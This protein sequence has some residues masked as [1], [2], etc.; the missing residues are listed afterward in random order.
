MIWELRYFFRKTGRMSNILREK[1]SYSQRSLSTESIVSTDKS[2]IILGIESSCDDSGCG[3]VDINKN[4]L[5]EGLHSQQIMHL[6]MGGIIPPIAGNIHRQNITRVCEDALRSAGLRLRDVTAIATTVKPGLSNSLQIGLTFGKY[7]TR[8]GNKPFIPIHH[9]EAHALTARLTTEISFPF[10]VLLV[11][12]GHSILTIAKDVSTFYMLG[13][14]IDNS[15]GELIDK[16]SRRLKLH[17]I[18]GFEKLS[19]GAALELAASKATDITQF[20]LPTSMNDVRDC[21]FSFSGITSACMKHI[22]DE[23]SKYDIK[24]D[25]TIP[26]VYNLCAAYQFAMIKHIC[27]RTQR[28]ILYVE[29]SNLIPENDRTLVVSGGVAS[30]NLLA[31]ALNLVCADFGYRFVRPPRKLCTDNGVMIAW[32]GMERWIENKGVIYNQDEIENVTI[33]AKA[34]LGEDWS[35]R[36]TSES[37]KLTRMKLLQRLF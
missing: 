6:K 34:S 11:S 14:S 1:T 18:P 33:D 27:E 2:A 32:N 10:L 4:I 17:Y 29:K 22:L 30:N 20:P 25:M 21:H 3:I 19:G 36:I 37:I 26:G 7:L 16:V 9:M 8:V 28:A 24:A 13:T 5:G 31:K 23:E 35:K 12:G 15:P